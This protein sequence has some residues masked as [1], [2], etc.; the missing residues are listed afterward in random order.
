MKYIFSLLA[1]ILLWY[2]LLLLFEKVKTITQR[3]KACALSAKQKMGKLKN[4]ELKKNTLL[5]TIKKAF[6]SIKYKKH[7]EFKQFIRENW[8]YVL[9]YIVFIS[10][11]W[12]K[13]IENILGE[14][15][16]EVYKL[17]ATISSL[18]FIIFWVLDLM[19]FDKNKII[20]LVFALLT[21]LIVMGQIWLSFLLA[22]MRNPNFG[23]VMIAILFF[24]L[25]FI[26]IFKS[27]L[28][29]CSKKNWITFIIGVIFIAFSE[30]YILLI[31][32]IYDLQMDGYVYQIV[33]CTILESFIRAIQYG[34]YIVFQSSLIDLNSVSIINVRIDKVYQFFI[35]IFL[36]VVFVGMVV[37]YAVT[38]FFESSNVDKS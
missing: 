30:A 25:P 12:E 13:S 15:L 1:L 37:S 21:F 34:A 38:A 24:I 3:S 22:V 7:N 32:G 19:N 17:L 4:L 16:F 35:G 2:I 9:S 6:V 36:N 5:K 14:S 18:Y 26:A 20:N 10:F 11:Q 31:L 33:N 23:M 27:I 29:F 8:V 28:N